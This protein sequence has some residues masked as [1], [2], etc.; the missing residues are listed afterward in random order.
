MK[1]VCAEAENT[2]KD[3]GS[4]CDG[5][6]FRDATNQA[7]W[8]RNRKLESEIVRLND[9]I[10]A[11]KHGGVSTSAAEE[12]E[13]FDAASSKPIQRKLVA[14]ARCSQCVSY[15]FAVLVLNLTWT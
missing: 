6:A 10:A 3:G 4:R 8:V 7:L 12:G 1:F 11:S 14:I 9:L 5:C 2:H 13:D 15:C